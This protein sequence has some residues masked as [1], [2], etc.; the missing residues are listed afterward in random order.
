VD[1]AHSVV[2]VVGAGTRVVG[3]DDLSLFLFAGES[4]CTLNQMSYE[5]TKYKHLGAFVDHARRIRDLESLLRMALLD[6]CAHPFQSSMKY[7]S[8]S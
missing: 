8:D 3:L 1:D 6:L 7:S 2:Y 5:L 4:K